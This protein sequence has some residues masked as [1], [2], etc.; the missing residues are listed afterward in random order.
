MNDVVIFPGFDLRP[1]KQGKPRM[2]CTNLRKWFETDDGKI[3]TDYLFYGVN[4]KYMLYSFEMNKVFKSV[5]I[6]SCFK[7]ACIELTDVHTNMKRKSGEMK[8]NGNDESLYN[9]CR[10]NELNTI[11]KTDEQFDMLNR[12]GEVID[13]SDLIPINEVESMLKQDVEKTVEQLTNMFKYYFNRMCKIYDI[14]PNDS[15]LTLQKAVIGIVEQYC[16]TK[17]KLIVGKDINTHM[18][19]DYR[20]KP[21][22]EV[23][24]EVLNDT[25]SW[26]IERKPP[27]IIYLNR[28]SLSNTPAESMKVDTSL[29]ATKKFN[30]S[31]QS[32]KHDEIDISQNTT[33]EHDEI[34]ISQNAKKKSHSLN[35]TAERDE[36]EQSMELNKSDLLNESTKPN[37]S[38]QPIKPDR[39]SKAY[40]TQLT[41]ITS[42]RNHK[43]QQTFKISAALLT[44]TIIYDDLTLKDVKTFESLINWETNKGVLEKPFITHINLETKTFITALINDDDD[45]FQYINMFPGIAKMY[46]IAK[47]YNWTYKIV[48]YQENEVI[49]DFCDSIEF[50]SSNIIINNNQTIEQMTEEQTTSDTLVDNI[51]MTKIKFR[52]YQRDCFNILS[53]NRTAIIKLPCGMGKTFIMVSHMFAQKYAHS[54]VLVPN[55]ALVDQFYDIIYSFYK[56]ENALDE[57]ELHRLSTRYKETKINDVSRKQIIISVY[58]SFFN[59]FVCP[60]MNNIKPESDFISPSDLLPADATDIR[61]FKRFHYMYVDEAHHVILPSNKCGK[62]EMKRLMEEF[63]NWFNGNEKQNDFEEVM[64][65]YLN[66]SK[67]GKKAFSTWIYKFSQL[68]CCHSYFFSATIDPADYNTYDMR[69]AIDEGYLCRLNIEFVLDSDYNNEDV[70]LERRIE[71]LK[72]YVDKSSRQAIII[73]CSR[74]STAEQLKQSLDSSKVVKASIDVNSR[75]KIFDEFLHGKLRIL[76]T[77]NCISEGVDLP[78]ADCAIFF[79]DKKSVINIIQCVGR[80][81]RTC[82]NKLSASLVLP[83]YSDDDMKLITTNMMKTLN[84]ELGYGSVDIKR[85]IS[86]KFIGNVQIKTIQELKSRLFHMLGVE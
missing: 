22:L 8:F 50:P 37:T 36:S 4:G 32:I 68:C 33:A 72:A 60:M 63:S 82:E 7:Q 73:Y 16:S 52:P 64:I 75:K 2:L 44:N 86:T 51:N 84:G 66:T 67:N 34:D 41:R 46:H 81:M 28:V 3:F 77:V 21:N 1:F 80:V 35:A 65:K 38:Q 47:L 31:K 43:P 58:N 69:K 29:N 6:S 48:L 25:G 56:R 53:A 49:S 85:I 30:K 15:Y 79:D 71:N 18:I 76:I 70:S 78:N 59:M 61:Q 12:L 83:V 39:Y 55:V 10:T 14:T 62:E 45:A 42:M 19:K 54:V 27:R 11:I 26:T 57:I 20:W 9:I 40:L 24:A 74:V 13:D 17:N 5:S 23:I